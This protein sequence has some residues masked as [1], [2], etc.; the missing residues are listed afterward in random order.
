MLLDAMVVAAWPVAA[1]KVNSVA[2][3]NRNKG[4]ASIP[5]LCDEADSFFRSREKSVDSNTQEWG[6]EETPPKRAKVGG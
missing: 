5:Q 3:M 2:S 4:G 1:Y 6:G